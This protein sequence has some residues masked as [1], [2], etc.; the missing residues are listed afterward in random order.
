VPVAEDDELAHPRWWVV[1]VHGVG[2]GQVQ[3]GAD[4]GLRVLEPAADEVGGDRAE[5]FGLPDDGG[6]GGEVGGQV[7]QGQVQEQG[8]GDRAAGHL[9]SLRCLGDQPLRCLGDQVEGGL[10]GGDDAEGLGRE[11]DHERP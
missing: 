10:A 7:G 9:P 2:A 3:D 4:G 1:P 6:T 11:R 5:A 8:G